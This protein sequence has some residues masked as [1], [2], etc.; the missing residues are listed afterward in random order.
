[1]PSFVPV[2]DLPNHHADAGGV[3]DDLSCA[4]ARHP[5]R[6]AVI[7]NGRSLSYA[8][9]VGRVRM[10]A[11]QL[12]PRCG[13]VAV[14]ATH[15][16]ETV[17]AL[18]GVMAAGGVYCPVDPAHPAERQRQLMLQAGCETYLR[19]ASDLPLP[20]L[21]AGVRLQAVPREGLIARAPQPLDAAIAAD[22]PAYLLFTSGSTGQPKGVLNSYGALTSA[23]R[24]LQDVLR[25]RAIDRVLQ[26]A[27]LNW[28]TCFEEIFPTLSAGATLV[29]DDD[30]HT[31]SHARFIRMLQA[32]TITVLDLPTAYWHELVHHLRDAGETLP[33]SVHT[34]VIGGEAASCARI[35]DWCA[36]DTAHIRLLNTYGSTETSLVTHAAE[37]NG[38]RALPTDVPW[39]QVTRAPIGHALPHV[40]EA[41]ADDNELWIG[42][43]SLALG[44]LDRPDLTAERFVMCDLGDGLRRYYR[45]GD[46]MRRRPDG[47]LVHAGRLD[48]QFKVRGTL[49]DPAEVEAEILRHPQVEAAAVI[50]VR[51]SE[52]SAAVAYVVPRRGDD[53]PTL[54]SALL[55]DLRRRLPAHLVPA[56]VHAVCALVR[57]ANGKVDRAATHRALDPFSPT[58]SDQMNAHEIAQIFQ[59]VLDVPEVKLDDDFFALGGDSLLATRIISALARG[60]GVELRLDDVMA[61]PTPNALARQLAQVAP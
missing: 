13:R 18:L 8:E 55:R 3:L 2:R 41:L 53:L 50:G 40:V 32:R 31:G 39:A 5:D 21:P 38:P 58:P 6:T 25:I 45:T 60:S 33:A 20:P 4:A 22:T 57:T 14:A 29:F 23:V 35:A 30:A 56:Q 44:Y 42:G 1:M 61:A 26:F 46:R 11:D 10:T 59:R 34:V 19:T 7:D 52:R 12:G 15:S 49:V 27:A 17:I 28:D 37:L 16:S 48:H 47:A 43:P 54:A 9:L 51:K 36:L 24:G